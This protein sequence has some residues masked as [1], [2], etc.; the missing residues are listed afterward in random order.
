M[1]KKLFVTAAVAAAISVPLAGVAWAD[2]P[3]DP[4]S[5]GN[6]LGSG[7]IPNKVGEVTTAVGVNPNPGDPE[8]PGETFNDA[9]DEFSGSTPDAYGQW[10]DKYIAPPLGLPSLGRTPPGMGT[11]ALTPGCSHGKT[12]GDLKVCP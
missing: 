8:T 2:P 7:G 12:A 10:V 9:K 1:F 5:N 3:T 6:G 11:K 4:S